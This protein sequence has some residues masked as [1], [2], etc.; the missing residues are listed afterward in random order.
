MLWFSP[1]NFVYKY[2][3]KSSNY[4]NGTFHLKSP[5]VPGKFF[6]SIDH[7]RTVHS[8]Q[9]SKTLFMHIFL[10]MYAGPVTQKQSFKPLMHG[11]FLYQ[12][13]KVLWERV[14]LN[15]FIYFY[16]GIRNKK[17]WNVKNFQVKGY[18]LGQNHG[19]YVRWQLRNS[20]ARK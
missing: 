8:V 9:S 3:N 11:R 18:L 14:K 19:T 10:Y 13:F 16:K 7:R 17:F 4:T 2:T 5:N 1:L 15:F 6:L 12:Y 20:Y